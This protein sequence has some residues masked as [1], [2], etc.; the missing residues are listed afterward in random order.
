MELK[1]KFGYDDSLDVFGVH[2]VG[3]MTGALLTGVFASVGASGLLLGNFSQ[4]ITQ[5]EG[6]VASAVYAAVGTLILGFVIN[7]TM[8]LKVSESE[9]NIGLDQTQHGEVAYNI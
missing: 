1:G 4:M 3:G 8:G 2:G 9:E 5:L 7:K 6:V